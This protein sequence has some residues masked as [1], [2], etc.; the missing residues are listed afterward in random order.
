MALTTQERTN[1][2][3]LVVA[4]F[5]AAP[6]ANY[7]ADLTVAYEANGRSLAQ[8]ARTLTGTDAY[9]AL[10]PVNQT[11]TDF[12]LSVLSPLGLQNNQTAVDFVTAKFNAGVP[13]GQIA[14]D[15]AVALDATTDTNFADAKL[16]L[17]NK[18]DVAEYF[19]VTTA[20][21]EI[22]ITNLRE[23]VSN[24]GKDTAS[25]VLAKSQID[26][27]IREISRLTDLQ[28]ENT[29]N[30][31]AGKII[32]LAKDANTYNGSD[33]PD[34]VA[35]LDGNDVIN[36]G[37]GRDQL[38]G[39]RGD[40]T[41][42]AGTYEKIVKKMAGIYE[43][44]SDGS[45][46]L[47]GSELV[48]TYEFDAFS[49]LLFG[50]P[51]NDTL[52]GGYGSDYLQGGQDNDYLYGDYQTKLASS[53][54]PEELRNM[55]NDTLFGGSGSDY[56]VAGDG[57]DEVRGGPGI[58][59]IMLGD[60]K[61]SAKDTV[62]LE[63]SEFAIFLSYDKITGF[64]SNEDTLKIDSSSLTTKA[65][66]IQPKIKAYTAVDTQAITD[67]AKQND[68]SVIYLNNDVLL[69]LAQIETAI[70]AG[71][72]TGEKFIFIEVRNDTL[73]YVDRLAQTYEGG[74]GKG[75]F[76]LAHLVG[77]NGVATGDLVVF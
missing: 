49:E 2:I 35:G 55:L 50:G 27:A 16:I 15:V 38:V 39:G 58:D 70:A 53:A 63:P 20:Q 21:A 13:K 14:Y 8:L 12:Y 28:K 76:L 11:A 33:G 47:I 18:T 42:T 9:K 36:G 73:L 32:A 48:D 19:S 56:I 60:L 52:M 46:H 4:M 69:T 67:A 59:T 45:T 51:G 22:N 75:I 25:V 43:T 68:G 44:Y 17:K 41:L 54:T 29:L 57:S 30:F 10:N 6:G 37:R 34:N 61:V 74:E 72:S 26:Y 7:L 66:V 71:T 40:D 23:V 1:I 77:V 24:V 64:K 62:F 3:K 5:N 65:L 31:F